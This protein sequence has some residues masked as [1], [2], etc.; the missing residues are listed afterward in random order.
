[1]EENPEEN[2]HDESQENI[3]ESNSDGE[4]V[5]NRE[6]VQILKFRLQK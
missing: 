5:H 3:E 4:T 1:M 2:I 6:K